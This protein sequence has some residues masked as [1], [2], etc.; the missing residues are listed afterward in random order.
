MDLGDDDLW[1]VTCDT[2]DVDP[3][4]AATACR[5]ILSEDERGRLDRFLNTAH[6]PQFLAGH[7]L[8]RLLLTE[9]VPEV[10][11]AEWR[12]S[13]TAHGRPEVA[14]PRRYQHL[15]FNMSHTQGLV[16]CA[17][18]WRRDVGVD[19]ERR[20]PGFAHRAVADQFFSPQE[21]AALRSLPSDADRVHRFF[22][23]WTLKE[24]YLTARGKGLA[25]PLGAFTM[26]LDPDGRSAAVEFDEARIPDHG[27]RWCLRHSQVTP[28][29]LLATCVDQSGGPPAIRSAHVN[30][31][32]D[33]RSLGL[34]WL[35]PG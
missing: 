28:E 19:V 3:P 27:W 2:A 4:E 9:V 34:R 8:I 16:A 23:Y 11:P 22:T 17:V 14:E 33:G 6:R 24:A 30:I 1:V 32:A 10:A 15:R 25:L 5:A 13:S 35:A 31:V 12:F 20:N 7:A 29:H 21:S 26:H 18:V